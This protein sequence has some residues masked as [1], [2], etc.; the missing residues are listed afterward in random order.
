MIQEAHL[1][2]GWDEGGCAEACRSHVEQ[3][4][5]GSR[6]CRGDMARDVSPRLLPVAAASPPH[7]AAASRNGSCRSGQGGCMGPRGDTAPRDG[8]SP[9]TEPLTRSGHRKAIRRA[10]VCSP[11]A[12]MLHALQKFLGC[13][14]FSMEGSGSNPAEHKSVLLR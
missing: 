2:Q 9:V 3:G 6:S 11:P 12:Q 14:G 10:W 5:R 1:Q 13:W 7:A 4:C 8:G